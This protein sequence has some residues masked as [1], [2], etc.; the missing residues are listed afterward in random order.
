[1][2]FGDV[3]APIRGLDDFPPDQVPRG[4]E[5]W[6]SFVSF[7]NMV[8]LGMYFI[9]LTGL[10]VL[11]LWKRTLFE[12][13]WVLKLFAWSIPLPIAACQLG[14]ITAE[15]GRQ[16]WIVYGLL[17]TSQGASVVVS[18]AEIVFS[19]VL[20]GIIYLLL[21]GLW[22]YLLKL[23]VDAGPEQPIQPEEKAREV[24]A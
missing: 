11:L 3:N 15:V 10:A 20:F 8:I 4:A 9:G 12:K 16:P 21:G 17:K 5:L 13:R 7:H 19:I 14:W 22:I 6:L 18:A 1:M 2:A 24:L 23:K